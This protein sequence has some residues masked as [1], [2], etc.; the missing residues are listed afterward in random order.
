M[1]IINISGLKE[2]F[3]SLEI[4]NESQEFLVNSKLSNFKIDENSSNL[5]VS[6]NLNSY[7][8]KVKIDEDIV[9]DCECSCDIHSMSK[10]ICSHIVYVIE[11]YNQY[12]KYDFN[13]YRDAIDVTFNITPIVKISNNGKKHIEVEFYFENSYKKFFIN[14]VKDLFQY[15][16]KYYFFPLLFFESK[17]M[18]NE[19]LNLLNKLK[20]FLSS[21]QINFTQKS[22][23]VDEEDIKDWIYFFGTYN[24]MFCYESNV[25]WNQTHYY[26]DGYNYEFDEQCKYSI[27]NKK[28]FLLKTTRDLSIFYLTSK[29]DLFLF[30][31]SKGKYNIVIYRYSLNLLPE[32]ENFNNFINKQI[33]KNN[34][35]RLYLSI[36]KLFSNYERIIEYLFIIKNNVSKID[37]ILEV[38]VYYE[39]LL[40]VLVAK[41]SFFYGEIEYPYKENETN[42]IKRERFLEQKLL[43]P[44]L[45]V[46]N[47]YNVE[48]EVFEIVDHQK[49]LDFLSWAKKTSKNDLYDI[50]ISENLIFKPKSKKEF[51]VSGSSFENDFLKVSWT[52]EGFTQEDVL[53]ILAAYKQKLKYVTLSNNKIINLELDIDFEKLEED[54]K[55]LNTSID[56]IDNGSILVNKL[57]SNYF[58]ENFNV[59]NS[60][61]LKEHVK[62]LYD[63]ENGVKNELPPTL[64]NILKKYQITGYLW[65]KKLLSLNAG[66]ILADEMGL[67][68]TMQTISL[69]SDVY[70]NNKTRLP[71][72]I[73]CP[74]S[75]VYNWKKELT[76]FAP[77]LKIGIVDGNQSERNQVFKKMDKFQIIVTSYNLLNKDMEVYK[78][79]EFYLQILDEA[80][81]IK[82]HIT[83]FSK[84][85]K[86]INSKYKI[87]LTGTPI[88]NNL[89]ELWSIFDYVMPGF[90]YDSK[91][92]KM[93]F[94][95]KIIGKDEEALKKLKTKIA[96]FILRRTKEEVLKEL[97]SKTYKIMTCEFEQKQKEMYFSELSKSKAMIQQNIADNTINKK[98]ILIF[99]I[100]TKLRQICCSPKLLYENS[101]TNGAKFNLCIELIKDLIN[102]NDKILLFSQFT[103]MI[104]LIAAELKKLKI[105]FLV[106]TGDT[107]KKDRMD[108]VNQ[109]NE[110]N[111]IKVFLISLKAGG[112]GLT[113]TSANAVIHYD[114][115]W[116]MSLE[117]QAT[118]RA[119][120]IGQQKNVFIYKLIVKDSI[121]E[122]ILSLQESK[123]EIIEQIFDETSS[124]KNLID[125]NEILKILDIE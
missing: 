117:N 49:Y 99:S 113:L 41:I 19:S 95:D 48:F 30:I 114:P 34:F 22:I 105:N 88:E 53:K 106:L 17:Q 42:Y 31:Q 62:K 15:E 103:S 111:N 101:E 40:N 80:Q 74:S 10:K 57:N 37:P 27:N 78:N 115:W 89:L 71:S 123:K 7:E 90:L 93:F 120:R 125:M 94:Q 13:Q 65:L 1:K 86:S 14:N 108:L 29:N 66:G 69:L 68:K 55:L 2:F 20:E 12:V 77:F 97:P 3:Y 104:E 32:V 100:L 23:L 4:T 47:Y 44:I 21:R 46:F 107:N 85:T 51:H 11:L 25:S 18:S 73:I 5:L 75:L 98:N 24:I 43:E 50:K 9:L 63:P 54:M 56:S 45:S 121:E 119:H 109:F 16:D 72:L 35:Y 112:T 91:T 52:I 39:E 61:Q 92:F 26:L 96:P 122:K 76:Q 84:D 33:S 102:N 124:N 8:I 38:K 82:N 110:K 64:K 28:K 79:M 70:Y 36:K 67:G 87:A 59:S 58:L 116:N 60:E 6:C 118:D 83:Q 81:K